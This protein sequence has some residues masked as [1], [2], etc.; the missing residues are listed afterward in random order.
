VYT[1]NKILITASQNS[2]GTPVR[3]S[4]SHS[5]DTSSPGLILVGRVG[6]KGM[7]EGAKVFIIM[8]ERYEW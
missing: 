6:S 2:N 8:V 5:L 3:R 1:C 7:S 4:L